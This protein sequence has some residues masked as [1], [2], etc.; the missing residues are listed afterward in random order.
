MAGDFTKQEDQYYPLSE[1]V[2]VWAQ[3]MTALGVDYAGATLRLDLLEREG[4]YNN[5]FCHQPVV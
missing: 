5:G 1:M 2:D 3:S 4:K